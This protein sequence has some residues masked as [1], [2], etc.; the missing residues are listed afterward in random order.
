MSTG[1]DSED[2]IRVAVHHL[3][4]G[5][6]RHL[7]IQNFVT[8]ELTKRGILEVFKIDGTSNPADAQSKVLYRILSTHHFDHLQ[9]YNGLPYANHPFFRPNPNDNTTDG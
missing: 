5:R 7:D 6:T 1:E 9:G 8:Q 4:S 3:S 2:T